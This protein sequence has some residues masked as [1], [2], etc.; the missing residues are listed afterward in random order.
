MFTIYYREKNKF[1]KLTK[2]QWYF[3]FGVERE[4]NVNFLRVFVS[5]MLKVQIVL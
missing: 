1:N 4:A 5:C 2:V 3:S